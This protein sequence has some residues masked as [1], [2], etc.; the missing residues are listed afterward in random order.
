MKREQ[1]VFLVI[2]GGFFT[3]AFEV[4]LLHRDVLSEHWQALIPIYFSFFG[5]LAGLAA[6][7]GSGVMRQ[8]AALVF[9]IGCLVGLLGLYFHSEGDATKLAEPFLGSVVA[10]AKDD[11]DEQKQ[12]RGNGER[13]GG[14][15]P[16]LAPAGIAG[17]S[18]IGLILAWPK[19]RQDPEADLTGTKE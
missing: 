2:A 10:Q 14:N 15:A 3:M 5:V 18:A 7:L 16:A 9:G 19:R 1:L 13:E 17:L 6:A 4:R 11:D 8:F 12:E